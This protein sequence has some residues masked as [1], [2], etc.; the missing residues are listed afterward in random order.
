MSEIASGAARGAIAAM[1]M[2]GMRRMTQG[3]GLVERPPPE[4]MAREGVPGIFRLA[5]PDKRREAIELAHWAFGAG[6]GAAFGTLPRPLREHRL[7]GPVYGLAIWAGFELVLRRLFRLS[8]PRRKA[9]ERVALAADHVLYGAV[10][11]ARPR[12][13]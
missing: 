8:Q 11:A 2:T 10:V 6:A 13:Q 4:R 5:P 7:A 9:R 3:L 1:A 12:P